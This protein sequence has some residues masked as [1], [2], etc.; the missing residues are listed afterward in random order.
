MPH[1]IYIKIVCVRLPVATAVW[2]TVVHCYWMLVLL[3]QCWPGVE[4]SYTS[5]CLSFGNSLYVNYSD[6]WTHTVTPEYI[7]LPHTLSAYS[8]WSVHI[9]TYSISQNECYLPAPRTTGTPFARLM[10]MGN[11]LWVST[12]W[13]LLPISRDVQAT[14]TCK[15]CISYTPC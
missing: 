5:I 9:F 6:G 13:V 11:P 7:N 3:T 15:Y 2:R 8:S 14:G 10:C 4:S 12:I 1:S